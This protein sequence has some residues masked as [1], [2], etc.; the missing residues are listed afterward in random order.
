MSAL[1]DPV[2]LVR[3]DAVDRVAVLR[4]TATVLTPSSYAARKARTAI[5]PRLATST[6]ANMCRIYREIV[7]AARRCFGA[8]RLGVPRSAPGCDLDS[9]ETVFRLNLTVT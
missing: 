3:L 6:L 7:T 4:Y 8:A 9:K 2:R 5:S 1:A